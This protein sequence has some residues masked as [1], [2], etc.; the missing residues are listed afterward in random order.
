MSF[1]TTTAAGSVARRE[2]TVLALICAAHFVSHF[3]ILVL[4][5]LFPVLKDAFAVSYLELGL[6]LTVFNVV[7]ALTQAPVGFLADR[8]GPA[9]LLVLGLCLGGAAFIGFALVGSYYALI[10][11]GAIAGL[12][13]SIY[14][15]ADYSILSAAIGKERIG[16]AFS[17]HAFAGFLG[18]AVAPA[19]LIFIA[20]HWDW[21]AAILA[22][23]LLGPAVALPLLRSGLTADAGPPRAAAT[24]AGDAR[25][26]TV[27]S[28]AILR[29][30]AFF[31]LLSLSTNGINSFAVAAL[32]DAYDVP[33]ALANTALTA[34]LL[35]AAF[36]VLA[37]GIL[38]DRT[39]RHGRVAALGFAVTGLLILVIGL[40]NLPGVALVLALGA[41][42]FASGII[43]PSRDM[44]VRAAAPPGAAGRAF[45]IVSTGLNMGGAIAPVLFGW[46]V[47][48]GAPR[49]VFFASAALC[50][51]TVA[52]AALGDRRARA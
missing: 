34:W 15:P 7:S 4:P 18:G 52:M 14:H 1:S 16:R 33:L 17:L 28:G 45:G 19:A 50:A 44:L 32:V 3:H 24:E 13:N 39:R 22:A 6:A 40:M 25:V 29:L 8:V 47:D 38:A 46:I 27:F 20:S 26:T 23:G 35:A 42:G 2:P 21:R 51:V 10:L 49:W 11:A 36:G 12:A 48:Q 37:G 5:P 30:T 43:L 9:R 31:L 41:A